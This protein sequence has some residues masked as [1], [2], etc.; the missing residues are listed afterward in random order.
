MT[1]NYLNRIKETRNKQIKLSK[2]FED[3]KP[4]EITS[5]YWIWAENDKK[6]YPDS[7][8][9]SGKWLIFADINKIDEIWKKVKDATENNL[10]GCF[11]KVST[12]KPNPNAQDSKS[13]VICVYTYDYEDKKD[14]MRIREELRKLGITFKIPYKSDKATLEGQYSVRGHKEISSYYC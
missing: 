2:P 9:R 4:S 6:H 12:A 8:E 3:S 10:L 14:V 13:K 7:T 11:S 5:I 1:K